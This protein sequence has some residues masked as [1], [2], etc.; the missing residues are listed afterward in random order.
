VS[1]RYDWLIFRVSEELIVRAK[2]LRA[3]ADQHFGPNAFD[4]REGDERWLGIIAEYLF[5][6]W[7]DARGI[8]YTWESQGCHWDFTI[9]GTHVDVKSSNRNYRLREDWES[10]A[11]E[12][13]CDPRWG[14]HEFFF[15][16]YEAPTGLMYFLG[17][18][19]RAR[20]QGTGDLLTAGMPMGNARFKVPPGAVLRSCEWVALIPPVVWLDQ[21]WPDCCVSAALA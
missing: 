19:E 9:R 15:T 12:K 1:V 2:R 20:M 14:I 11:H 13:H 10:V 18:I 4:A 6:C 5:A 21:F 16:T 17:G 3:W 7:L 8:A